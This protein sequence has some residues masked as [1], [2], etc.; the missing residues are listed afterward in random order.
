VPLIGAGQA[1]RTQCGR[2]PSVPQHPSMS[3]DKTM[4]Q[5]KF[6]ARQAVAETSPTPPAA[7]PRALLT[8]GIVAGPVFVIVM[9]VQALTRNGFDI[10][11]HP[12][13]LLSLGSLGWIQIVNFIIGGLLSLAF[14]VG[15][16]RA[17]H[18]GPAG[19]WAP[20]LVGVYGVGLIA[21]GIFVPDPALGF[22]PGT[23]AGIPEQLS[24][25]GM[26][27]AFAPP[28]AFPALVLACLVFVRRFAILRRWAWATYS[29]ATAV[30]ALAL[31]AWPGEEGLS[32][33]LA[34]AVVLTFAW[35]TAVAARVMSELHASADASSH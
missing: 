14:A 23:P 35:T 10:S 15:L 7:P 1:A 27:H 24:W 31:V 8:C 28:I 3:K 18:P 5:D 25:H 30:T 9:A 13:S 17:L 11:R 19:T 34:V 29:G 32:L 2:S 16:R 26:L 20:P 33:R 22:P 21:G 6:T 4:T 12:I